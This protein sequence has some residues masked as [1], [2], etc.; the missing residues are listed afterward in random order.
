MPFSRIFLREVPGT[1]THRSNYAGNYDLS[2]TRD[3]T[4]V[5]SSGV[6]KRIGWKRF[7]QPQ[8]SSP[9]D[10]HKEWTK[11]NSGNKFSIYNE[12]GP[13]GVHNYDYYIAPGGIVPVSGCEDPLVEPEADRKAVS[14][15]LEQLKGEGANVANMFAERHQLVKSVETVLN[16]VVYS[17]RDL[18]R[19]QVASAIRRVFG[20]AL[21]ETGK[22]KLARKLKGKDIANQ[23]LAMQYG[24]KPLFSDIYDLVNGFHKREKSI[25]KTFRASA[26]ARSTGKSATAWADAF[27]VLG[28]NEGFATTTSV[29]KY[30]I[31][32]FPDAALAE[33][34]ALGFTNPLVCLWE[35]TPW[36]FVVDWFLPVG[37]YLEQLTATHGWIFYDGCQTTL[38]KVGCMAQWSYG[39]TTYS[40]DWT[41]SYQASYYGGGTYVRMRRG[42]L[43]SFPTPKLPSFKNPLSLGHF[44]NGLA[45]L[46][47]MVG[48]K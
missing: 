48:H 45:L 22:K 12:Y 46:S 21:S 4:A 9:L 16:T 33:P 13:S 47:Q 28:G 5:D 11:W 20:D 34:A 43:A 14:N 7:P 29:V 32:A 23:W 8:K 19:G 17:I 1:A 38:T 42:T 27:K 2:W 30:M 3:F 18:K 25:P 40:G 35:V 37:N 31:R 41:Y 10:Y 39:K 15:V 44:W 24:W 6:Q 36:S 26:T